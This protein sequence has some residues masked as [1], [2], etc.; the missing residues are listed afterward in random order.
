M[1][2]TEKYQTILL[3]VRNRL[4]L[5]D[6]NSA[7]IRI[8][9]GEAAFAL[10]FE[11][12]VLLSQSGPRSMTAMVTAD[13]TKS[14]SSSF[15]ALSSKDDPEMWALIHRVTSLCVANV[16]T[17]PN[18]QAMK[19]ALRDH[20]VGSLAV[21]PLLW[22]GELLGSLFFYNAHCM[23]IGVNQAGRDFGGLFSMVFDSSFV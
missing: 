14:D 2:F 22:H 6:R 3:N 15:L 1:P 20:G 19:G 21:F 18:T 7:S 4:S 16:E 9:L 12:S 10:G 11:S 13:E 17:D 5:H 23:G 8:L